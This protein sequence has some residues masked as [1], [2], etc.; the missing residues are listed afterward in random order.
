V[1]ST[2]ANNNVSVVSGIQAGNRLPS[3]PRVQG[4]AAATYRWSA[5]RGSS[6]FLSA[7]AQHVGSRYTLIDDLGAGF[8]TVNL[9]ALPHTIGGPLTQN[10]FTFNP[11]LPAYTLANMR[12]GVTRIS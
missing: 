2:D 5:W 9:N 10:A 7:S 4:A 12:L 3:V 6:P 11:E 8:G 1:T